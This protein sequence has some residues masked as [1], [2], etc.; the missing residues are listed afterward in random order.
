MQTSFARALL[1]PEADLPAGLI[2]PAGLPAARRFAVYRNNVTS[3][4]AK[5]LEA[6]FP[7]VKSLVGE[8]FFAAM[9][10]AFL[11]QH[12]PQDRIMML[13]G[14]GFP[15]FIQGFLPAKDLGYLPDV[16]R[17]EQA[18]RESYHSADGVPLAANVLAAIPQQRWP[19][20]VLQLAPS[21]RIVRSAW[22]VLSVWKAALYA[23]ATPQMAAQDVVILRPAFDPEPHLLPTGGAAFITA[24]QDGLCFEQAIQRGESDL[25]LT[26]VLSL[27]MQGQAILGVEQWTR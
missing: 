15:A 19:H 2:G 3:G 14:A 4:L 1:D 7:A 27:L 18:L 23:G 11:R 10:L 16:A 13:Y 9:A 5:V 17:L 6:A 24:L 20:L 21:I 25:D 12:P 22:P 26:A 8:E